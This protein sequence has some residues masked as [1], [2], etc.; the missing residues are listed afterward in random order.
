MSLFV[1]LVPCVCPPPPVFFNEPSFHTNPQNLLRQYNKSGTLR[2]IAPDLTS[3]TTEV[4]RR[5]KTRQV[6]RTVLDGEQVGRSPPA[7][8]VTDLRMT[9]LNRRTSLPLRS[10]SQETQRSRRV[11]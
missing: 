4:D 2:G 10:C 6:V 5:G 3:T 11:R 1:A 7:L 8:S 9:P